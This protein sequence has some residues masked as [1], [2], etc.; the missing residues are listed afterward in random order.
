MVGLLAGNAAFAELRAAAA[1]ARQ[2]ADA[3]AAAAARVRDRVDALTRERLQA[4]RDLAA[5]Q[6]PELN[7]ATTA[8]AMPEVAAELV[9]FEQQRQARERELQQLLQQLERDM[10]AASDRLEQTTRELDEVVARRDERMRQVAEQ[11]Q[12]DPEY[13]PLAHEGTQAEVRLARDVAR[14]EELAA[15]AKAKLPPYERSRLFQYLWRRGFGTPQYRGRGFTARMDRR[16]AAF[17]RYADAVGSY[18]FLTTTPRL[19]RL[20][21]ER[22]TAEVAALR[23]RLEAKEDAVEAGLGVPELSAE[24][25]RRVAGRD[26][27]LEAIEE[28]RRRIAAAHTALREEAGSRGRFHADALQRLTTFLER[29]ETAVLERQAAR[30]EDA[31]DDRLVAS[32]RSCT[33]ELA[34]QAAEAGPL[35]AAAVRADAI[36]DGLEDLLLRFRR[37]D[38]DAGRSE[39]HDLDLGPLLREA[40]AGAVAA[41][42]V[43]QVLRARQRFRRPPA[44]HHVD[45]S[46]GVLGGIGLALRVA[47][48]VLDATASSRRGGS[49]LGGFGRSI[50]RTIGSSG[51]FST[52]RTIGG[53]GGFSTGR[54]F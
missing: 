46:D 36:A 32:L 21:V 14:A 16:L 40:R 7:A 13:A 20:E 33:E 35:D 19:V 43:W 49:V 23:Q 47:G 17:V 48:V 34:R 22:R 53:G 11:L 26:Q 54:R 9:R 31:T 28:L 30:T 45:R 39:F 42:D 8:G 24:I 38:F 4:L 41:D 37:A 25:D 5:T 29:T 2:D 12:Q 15:E 1:A 52:G 44:V 6:L 10:A 51:G 27:Q 3:A 18:R 50:G